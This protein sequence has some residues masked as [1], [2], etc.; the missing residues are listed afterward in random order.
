[1]QDNAVQEGMGA[2]VD[3]RREH[4]GT[5]DLAIIQ[6]RRLYL[7]AARDLVE[8]GI[9]PPGVDTAKTYAEI[10]SYA[11][12]QPQSAVWHEVQPLA[13]QFAPKD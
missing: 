4:L 3:R 9:E 12:L 2:I 5:A 1:V 6:A 10:Q 7:R 8:H 13:P 11:Y